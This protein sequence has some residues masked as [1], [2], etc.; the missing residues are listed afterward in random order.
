MFHEKETVMKYVHTNIIARD[1][2]TLSAFYQ[3]VFA[4]VP[5]PPERNLSGQ[6]LD[7]MTGIDG[8]HITGEHL[9]LPGHGENGPTLEIFSY[10]AMTPHSHNINMIGLAHLAFEVDDVERTVEK[11]IHHGGKVFGKVVQRRY[12]GIGDATFVYVEDIEGNIIELQK[13]DRIGSSE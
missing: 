11:V 4:C 10:D 6:W 9:R 8:A 3:A 5:V 1:W 13:W 12:E 7:D 2:Q